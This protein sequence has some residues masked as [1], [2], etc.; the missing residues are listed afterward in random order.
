[1]EDAYTAHAWSNRYHPIRDYLMDLKYDGQ[2]HIGH[3]ASYFTDEHNVF[4][5]WIRRWL[6][7]ACARV[8]A[9][10][11]NRVLVIDGIQGL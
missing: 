10:E 4:G 5:K 8:M 2:D 6:V 9:G 3:F 7:G 1:M 11:Q